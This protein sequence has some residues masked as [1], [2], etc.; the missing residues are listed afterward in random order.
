MNQSYDFARTTTIIK[1]L[2]TELPISKSLDL[3]AT[4]LARV[5][6]TEAYWGQL[7]RSQQMRGEYPLGA[8]DIDR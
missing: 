6:S 1:G 2:T 8:A 5:K 3:S 7:E 4:D